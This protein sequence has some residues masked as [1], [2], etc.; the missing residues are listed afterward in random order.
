MGI[1]IERKFLIQNDSWREAVVA[2]TPIRQGY[3]CT[4]PPTAIRVRIA[5]DRATLNVKAALLDI[6]RMEFEYAIP[7]ADAEE[8]LARLCEGYPIEKTRHIIEHEGTR[9]EVD[10]FN[11]ENRGLVV[12]EVE[13]LSRDAP[14]ARPAWLGAEVS[15]DPRYLNSYLTR[16][17]F[18]QW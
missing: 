2:A 13:L 12:A 10:E 14:F 11:T 16:H 18:A 6:E 8:I 3:L 5:G 1:E 15:D 17:P 9:W 4:G 7:I